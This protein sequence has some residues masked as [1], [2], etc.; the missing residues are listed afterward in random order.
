VGGLIPGPAVIRKSEKSRVIKASDIGCGAYNSFAVD[1]DGNLWSWG[2][3]SYGECGQF[4]NAGED[5]ALV[6]YPTLV[7]SMQ[8][9]GSRQITHIEGGAHHT[10]AV[11]SDGECLVWGRCDGGQTGIELSKMNKDHVITSSGSTASEVEKKDGSVET[12]TY[13]ILSHPTAI[14]TVGTYLNKGHDH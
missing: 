4:D 14:P 1:K 7:E 6:L 3:N 11:T 5:R 10:I 2:A 13:K 9:E 12:R 8:Q